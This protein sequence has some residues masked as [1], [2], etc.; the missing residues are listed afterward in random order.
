MPRI[1]T[2]FWEAVRI[3]AVA[4]RVNKLRSI[5]TSLG[6]IIGIASVTAM[7]TVI[8]GIEQQFEASLSDLGTDVLYVDKWPWIAGPGTKWWEYIN[9][10]NIRPELAEVIERRARYSSAAAPVVQTRRS[11]SSTATTL[12]G[13][14]IHASTP[15]FEFVHA[16]DLAEGRL[17]GDMD[18]RAARNVATIGSRV[19]DELFP[20]GN[21]LGK[22]IRVGGH[23]FE[24]IGVMAR[25]GSGIDG[26]NSVDDQVR[27]PISTFRKLFGLERRSVTIEVKALSPDHVD[28]AE[29]ELTGILRTARG[30]DAMQA[31]DFDI[32][33]Q[34]S[35]RRQLAP[36]KL[37]IYGVGIFLT[38]LS[39]LVG[40]I[41]VMNIMYVSVKERT[42]EIGL[43]KAV[44]ARRSTVLIQFLVEAVIVCLIGGAIGIGISFILAA[45]INLVVSTYL[46]LSTVLMA[47]AI[48]VGIGIIFGL[49]PAWSAAKSEPIESLRYE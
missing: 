45:L 44:G 37:A 1:L 22:Y 3:A 25:K 28:L 42:R 14:T 29:D 9:R 35:L 11:V 13:V 34:E 17:Y 32:N 47:F 4:I 2:D 10:P 8:N 40:G 24:V 36:I 39:L 33:Q 15:R 5:L 21:A 41:G 46:P 38:A 30:I 12:S 7:V 16:V 19:A 23:R 26:G 48:C 18:E 20:L 27:I 31:N 6:I 43:R 49:A